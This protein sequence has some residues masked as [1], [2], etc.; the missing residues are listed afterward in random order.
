MKLR[1]LILVSSSTLLIVGCTAVHQRR[2][3]QELLPRLC[4]AWN[5]DDLRA[6][7]QLF[8]P[9]SEIHKLMSCGGV[10]KNKLETK[11]KRVRTESGRIQN[12]AVGKYDRDTDLYELNVEYD[13]KGKVVGFISVKQYQG[14]WRVFDID[15]D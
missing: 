7:E 5:G 2:G 3:A 9:E 1:N 15:I 4:E 10:A 12:V 14:T 6:F 8:H 13:I 11:F